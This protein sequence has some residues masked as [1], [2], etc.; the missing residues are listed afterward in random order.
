MNQYLF[1]PS[2]SEM[3]LIRKALTQP[4]LGET[5]DIDNMSYALDLVSGSDSSLDDS[6]IADSPTSDMTYRGT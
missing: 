2:L 6:G 4:R 1:T 5:H 3:A